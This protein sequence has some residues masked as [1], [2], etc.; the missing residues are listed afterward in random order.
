MS[1]SYHNVS[2]VENVGAGILNLIKGK[3]V[4]SI[5]IIAA[6]VRATT[7]GAK[8]IIETAGDSANV[9][10]LGTTMLSQGRPAADWY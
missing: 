4:R 5:Y 10:R 1:S 7:S 8:S 9:H 6:F 3:V 2:I